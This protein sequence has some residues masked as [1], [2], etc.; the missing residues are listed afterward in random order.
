MS[1]CGCRVRDSV[2]LFTSVVPGDQ[3]RRLSRRRHHSCDAQSDLQPHAA[4][5]CG[6]GD[7]FA[8]RRR[9]AASIAARELTSVLPSFVTGTVLL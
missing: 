4:V 1:M 6:T 8:H 3:R 2:G 9:R 7:R 5:P